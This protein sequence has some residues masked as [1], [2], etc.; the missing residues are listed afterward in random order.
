MNAADIR[1]NPHAL[2]GRV[3]IV[4]GASSGLGEQLAR[5]LGAAG[6]TPVLAAR[7][8][9]RLASLRAQLPGADTVW[10]A[11]APV[12]SPGKPVT[13]SWTNPTG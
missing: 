4:T 2:E 8:E 13:L 10:P 7:R 9:D 3:V 6:A 1:S 11:S 5:A 12:L